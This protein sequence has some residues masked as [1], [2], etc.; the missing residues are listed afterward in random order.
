MR[1]G[2]SSLVLTILIIRILDPGQEHQRHEEEVSSLQSAVGDRQLW[3]FLFFPFKKNQQVN[4]QVNEHETTCRLHIANCLYPPFSFLCGCGIPLRGPSLPR[5]PTYQFFA[6][7]QAISL[8]HIL[9]M[10]L[11]KYLS[12]K[13]QQPGCLAN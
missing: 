7:V 3:D 12:S 10:C 11:G 8:R 4:Q 13:Q 6:V 2:N 5:L 9:A 1:E